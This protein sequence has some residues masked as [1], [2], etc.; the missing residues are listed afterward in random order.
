VRSHVRRALDLAIFY[1]LLPGT[2][3]GEAWL[4]SSWL[5]FAGLVVSDPSFLF[6]APAAGALLFACSVTHSHNICCYRLPT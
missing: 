1:V 5:Q 2:G 3:F 4:P 6:A